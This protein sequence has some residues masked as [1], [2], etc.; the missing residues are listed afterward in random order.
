MTNYYQFETDNYEDYGV[1]DNPDLDG[2]I[3]FIAGR[4]IKEALPALVFEVDFPKDY[5]L[6]HFLGDI[7]PLV[8][9]EVVRLLEAIGIDNFQT[10]PVTLINP[11]TRQKWEGYSAFNVLGL[12]KAV[13]MKKS[14]ADILM[15]QDQ[16]GTMPALVAFRNI[17]LEE[18]KI[19]GLLMFRLAESP[20]ELIVHERIF[21]QFKKNRPKDGEAWGIDFVKIEVV[22]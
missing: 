14:D 11:E 6:P 5:R 16:E 7:I 3:S 18:S 22:N 13:D 20:G 8:S 21:E 19:R 15:G 17:A 9:D 1:Q 10:F 4:L 12:V 2:K